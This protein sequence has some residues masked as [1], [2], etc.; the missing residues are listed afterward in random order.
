MAVTTANAEKCT[1]LQL[2]QS[3]DAIE[4]SS[5]S[6]DIERAPH[7]IIRALVDVCLQL[8]KILKNFA[9]TFV[10]SDIERTAP[11]RFPA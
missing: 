10:C 4:K 6:S 1:H 8:Q 5:M 11:V 7:A 2:D 9:V 3:F